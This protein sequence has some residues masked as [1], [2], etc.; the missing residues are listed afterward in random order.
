MITTF[1]ATTSALL[2]LTNG[3]TI[4][5]A[6]GTNQV[7]TD[8]KGWHGSA[9]MRRNST[10]RLWA[11]GNFMERGWKS[12]RVVTL[13]GHVSC[14][15]RAEAAALCDTYAALFGDGTP[16]VFVVNDLDQGYRQAEVVLAGAID[17]RWDGGL[18]VDF[19][20]DMEA[21]DPRKY[22]Q[23][24]SSMTGPSNPGGGLQFDLFTTNGVLDFST[25]GDSGTVTIQNQGT[26]DSP[27]AFDITGYA[28]GFTITE[29][30][31]GRQLIYTATV[32]DGDV[33]TLD[34]ADGSVT[35]NGTADRS[36]Y[37]S[38]RDWTNLQ[39][40]ASSTFLF[41]SN[42]ADASAKMT[43]RAASAWW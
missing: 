27:V 30:A 12:S 15:T 14:S 43:V 1:E 39:P 4:G 23:A 31:T 18:E 21:P 34:A 28:P 16:G 38:R 2:Q 24:L 40:G 9:G 35:L 26:A 33:L 6:P 17:V 5:L 37:L 7:V 29:E 13:S 22:G 36:S 10:P 3:G 20:V 25:G 32:M 8:I 41:E 42:G 19:D 11:H